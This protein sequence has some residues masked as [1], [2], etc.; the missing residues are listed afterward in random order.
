MVPLLTSYFV[1]SG[2]SGRVGP[3][4]S[5]GE[6]VEV[7]TRRAGDLGVFTLDAVVEFVAD[8]RVLVGE[9]AVTAWAHSPR[10]RWF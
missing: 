8:G 1:A 9:E 2:P 7:Q 3:H 6:L 10:L 5:T 4:A